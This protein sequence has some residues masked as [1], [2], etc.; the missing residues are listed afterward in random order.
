MNILKAIWVILSP[1]IWDNNIVCYMFWIGITITY[2]KDIKMEINKI[3]KVMVLAVVVLSVG[4]SKEEMITVK[5]YSDIQVVADYYDTSIN[6]SM[7]NGEVKKLYKS[8][9]QQLRIDCLGECKYEVGG[10]YFTWATTL[11]KEDIGKEIKDYQRV[12]NNPSKDIKD[13][14]IALCTKY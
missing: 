5:A 14:K 4:C 1:L 11:L 10:Q 6:Q 9:L 3:L 7:R 2:Y 12:L 8:G 13:I